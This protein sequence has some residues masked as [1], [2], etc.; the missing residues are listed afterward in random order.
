MTV[1][2]TGYCR[3]HFSDVHCVPDCTGA[4]LTQKEAAP[5][6]PLVKGWDFAPA[7]TLAVIQPPPRSVP[8]DHHCADTHGIC[9]RTPS[10]IRAPWDSPWSTPR[11]RPSPAT[12]RPIPSAACC[13]IAGGCSSA[14]QQAPRS[15]LR[16]RH[17]RLFAVVFNRP[18]A[19]ARFRCSA[20]WAIP[21]SFRRLSAASPAAAAI[22]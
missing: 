2:G 3:A 21:P 18:L 15:L 8:P 9:S 16:R 6:R 4:P 19:W 13:V 10:A 20:M 11:R 1:V 5:P 12:L 22:S 7:A 17:P 14:R